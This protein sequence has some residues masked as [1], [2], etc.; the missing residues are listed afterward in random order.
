ML[1]LKKVDLT[2][3]WKL[4]T[5]I[6]SGCDTNVSKKP[7]VFLKLTCIIPKKKFYETLQDF[8]IDWPIN[9]KCGKKI[10]SF[11]LLLSKLESFLVSK[12]LQKL[13]QL[14]FIGTSYS[15]RFVQ[16]NWFAQI[17]KQQCRVLN[18]LNLIVHIQ[19]FWK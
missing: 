7:K 18:W 16:K 14:I 10:N 6:S 3:S 11:T 9:S 17:S 8:A 1:V 5:Q 4:C 2:P 15:F 13:M 12:S 19:R